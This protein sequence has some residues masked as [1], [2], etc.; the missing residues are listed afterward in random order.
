MKRVFL[1]TSLI[2]CYHVSWAQKVE[3]ESATAVNIEELNP[4]VR[5]YPYLFE[6]EMIPKDKPV[7]VYEELNTGISTKDIASNPDYW[8]NNYV[9]VVK[10]EMMKKHGADAILSATTSAK[11]VGGKLVVV[12]R[13]YPV[14]YTNFRRATKDDL[15]ILEFEKKDLNVWRYSDEE[16][17]KIDLIN[18]QSNQQSTRIQQK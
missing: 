14:K 9:T 1:I 3:I 18:L 15:W 7:A 10:H 5:V 12:V 17:K 16:I 8:I 11:T 6:Y 4:G 13:G 2:V